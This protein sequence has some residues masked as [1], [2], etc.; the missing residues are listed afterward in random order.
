[1]NARRL[2]Q[3]VVWVLFLMTLGGCNYSAN[4]HN[5]QGTYAFQTGNVTQ[6]IN[7]FQ[8]ALIANPNDANA[9]YNLG[10]SYAALGKQNRNAQWTSEAEQLFRRSIALN[11]QHVES[12]RALAAL[13]IENG[14]AQ[15]AFDLMN[16]W[17]ERYPTSSAPLIEL[18]KLYQESG[19]NRRAADLLAD[20]LRLDGSNPAA[21]RSLGQIREA[22][23]DLNL[24]LQNYTR[25]LQFNRA[26]N[27][28]VT[29]IASLQQRLAQQTGNG[30]NP[31][32][33][34]A[35]NPFVNR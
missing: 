35:A 18:A 5:C 12:H 2:N 23:G 15:N 10:Y 14:Q 4:R 3:P 20:S 8:Q 21:F 17:R 29:K 26:Q 19:D 22:Q 25:S 1:M 16:G 6:A 30:T 34:G 11:D 24:A 31:G 27:D 28:L 32:R 33:Y 9:Y 7:Q 13:L